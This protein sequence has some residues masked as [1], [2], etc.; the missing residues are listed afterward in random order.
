MD[1]PDPFQALKWYRQAQRSG[2]PGANARLTALKV[3]A[4]KRAAEGDTEAERL[5][6]QWESAR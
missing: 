6:L 5:L 1:E 3:W 4:E 2:H